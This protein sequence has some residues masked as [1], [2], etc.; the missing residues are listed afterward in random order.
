MIYVTLRSTT[1]VKISLFHD[2][3]PPVILI[4]NITYFL[5]KQ[6]IKVQY[7]DLL[8]L[9]LKFTK[10]L[11]SFFKQKVSF[12]SKFRSHF[13]VT[14]DHSSVLFQLKFQ[15]LWTKVSHQSENF[16]IAIARIK[17]HQIPHVIFGTKS[18]FFLKLYITPQCHET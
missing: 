13:S 10:F 11:M 17:F 1:Y 5:Q 7:S 4:S 14:R 9:A 3:S 16:R 18:Q 2:T 15:M 8:L 6:P 12:S